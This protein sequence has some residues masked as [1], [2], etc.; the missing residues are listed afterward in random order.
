MLRLIENRVNILGF[1]TKI[2]GLAVDTK[3]DLELAKKL[4]NKNN[5]K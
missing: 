1:L 5:A 3:S 4:I 2:N